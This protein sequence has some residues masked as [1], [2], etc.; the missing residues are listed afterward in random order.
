MSKTRDDNLPQHE[1]NQGHYGELPFTSL[2]ASGLSGGNAGD[3]FIYDGSEWGVGTISGS[4]VGDIT[5]LPTA[6]TDSDLVLHPDGIGG[7]EWGLDATS[8]GTV[9]ACRVRRDAAQAIVNGG[10]AISW[11]VEVRDDGGFW[12]AGSPTRLTA[13]DTAWYTI[14]AVG[15]NGAGTQDSVVATLRLNGTT[16]ISYGRQY[17]TTNSVLW[18]A[19]IVGAFYLSGSDYVEFL[20]DTGTSQNVLGES[21]NGPYLNMS[22]VQIH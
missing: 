11:D 1:Y 3:T 15:N 20:L 13:P 7:V 12:S 18:T 10:T 14:L 4:A 2:P 21:G 22:I 6:E 16:P 19:N 5:D 17:E 9:K 8:G